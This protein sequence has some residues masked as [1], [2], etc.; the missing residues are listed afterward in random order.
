MLKRKSTMFSA[1]THTSPFSSKSQGASHNPGPAK[2][3]WRIPWGKG[4]CLSGSWQSAKTLPLQNPRS[5]YNGIKWHTVM[6]VTKRKRLFSPRFIPAW[7]RMWD[8][9]LIWIKHL[10]CFIHSYKLWEGTKRTWC[11]MG[12]M[13]LDKQSAWCTSWLALPA[14]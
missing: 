4:A 9:T 3:C 2:S 7:E 8:V 5:M 14:S 6:Q 1:G 10:T 12:G 13:R 11:K